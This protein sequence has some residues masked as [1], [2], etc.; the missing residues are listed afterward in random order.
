MTNKLVPMENK[1]FGFEIVCR[2]VKMIQTP[3]QVMALF[4]GK[5]RTSFETNSINASQMVISVPT[6][7]TNIERQA[8]LDAAEIAGIKCI[9]LLNESTAIALTYGFF[10]K[11]E[12]DQKRPRIV[13]FVDFG[14]SKMTTTFCSFLPGRTKVLMTHSDRNIGAR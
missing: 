9:R 7:A 2:G 10:K 3:E 12:F 1:K 8:Y 13:A 5:I 14:H 11:S 4:L 6:Y